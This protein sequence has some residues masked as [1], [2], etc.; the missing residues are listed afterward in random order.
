M[1]GTKTLAF[2]I[3]EQLGWNSPGA[4]VVPVGNGTLLLGASIGFGELYSA[5]IVDNLPKIIAV[6]AENCAPLLRA[7]EMNQK[8][9]A[10]VNAEATVS[11]RN[12]D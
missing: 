10:D 2:E 9:S 3:C 12:C 1:H 7:F 6:Q 4:I 8:D 5:G 11:G